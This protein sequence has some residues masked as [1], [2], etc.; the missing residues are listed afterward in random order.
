MKSVQ[1]YR[2]FEAYR[3]NYDNKHHDLQFMYIFQSRGIKIK[4]TYLL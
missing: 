3:M 1:N 4:S 2:K